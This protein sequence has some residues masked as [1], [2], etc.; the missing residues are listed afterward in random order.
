M[1][2]AA[3]R[4]ENRRTRANFAAGWRDEKKLKENK[5]YMTAPGLPAGLPCESRANRA[6]RRIHF[7]IHWRRL[8]FIMT[9]TLSL[10]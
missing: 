4:R 6:G 10:G 7:V 8:V 5:S 9:L 1:T 2:T 3:K